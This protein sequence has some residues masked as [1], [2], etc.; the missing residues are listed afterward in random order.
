M[1]LTA[2]SQPTRQGVHWPQDS[3]AKNLSE[4]NAAC[5]ALSWSDN[6]TTAAEPIKQPYSCSVSKSSGM[7]PSEAGR[8]PPEAPPGK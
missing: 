7:S 6:T 8:I 1:M 5:L 3:C 4:F 2:F